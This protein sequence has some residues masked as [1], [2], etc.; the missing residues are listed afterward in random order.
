[1][2]AEAA[3]DKDYQQVLDLRLKQL[4]N[5]YLVKEAWTA[6]RDAQKVKNYLRGFPKKDVKRIDQAYLSQIR[7]VLIQYGF[8]KGQ[9][10]PA[11]V[12]FSQFLD[13]EVAKGR[14]LAVDPALR[15]ADQKPYMTMTIDDVMAIRDTIGNLE[16]AGRDL[17]KVIAEGKKFNKKSAVVQI[18]Q[19]M[20][21]NVRELKRSSQL[22]ASRMDLM[23]DRARNL[24]FN[25]LIKIE[26]ICD[27]IDGGAVQG[28]AH[29]YIFQPLADAQFEENR[30]TDL[31]SA[32]VLKIVEVWQGKYDATRQPI[33]GIPGVETITM[34]ERIS[35]ALNMG[36]DSNLKKMMDGR[37]WDKAQVDS[38]VEPRH[39]GSGSSACRDRTR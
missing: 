36:N 34:G 31:Y 8:I 25:S 30:L 35:V 17:N 39:G 14:V 26:Q 10:D 18:V 28:P 29:K 15:K 37:G 16:K 4:F 22:N 7:G 38:I 2:I 9:I 20:T 5:S 23:K 32:E 6:H 33:S 21:D 1:M 13:E 19:A 24:M 11:A 27:W 3:K 12:S